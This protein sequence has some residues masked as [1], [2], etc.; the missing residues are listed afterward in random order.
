MVF[1]NNR[2]GQHRSE[3]ADGGQ[4]S[5]QPIGMYDK[6]KIN[7][8]DLNEFRSLKKCSCFK[9]RSTVKWRNLK[10]RGRRGKITPKLESLLCFLLSERSYYFIEKQLRLRDKLIACLWS[11]FL[12]M[13]ANADI[14]PFCHLTENKSYINYPVPKVE[15]PT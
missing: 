6:K 15:F 14:K 1:K 9:W 2:L 11:N 8:R 12:M 3:K 7:L 10:H 5:H 13:L 4:K